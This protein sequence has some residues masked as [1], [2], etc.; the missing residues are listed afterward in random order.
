MFKVRGIIGVT[1]IEFSKISGTER[2]N[3]FLELETRMRLKT[4][5]NKVDTK[6]CVLWIEQ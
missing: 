2:V 1:K 3:F 4:L 5:H 6:Y